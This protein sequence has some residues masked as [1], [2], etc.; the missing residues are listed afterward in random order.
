MDSTRNRSRSSHSRPAFLT[1]TLQ[2]LSNLFE[3]LSRPPK[4]STGGTELSAV[5]IPG[6]GGHRI[7]RDSIDHAILLVKTSSRPESHPTPVRLENLAVD[8]EVHCRIWQD[9]NV[10]E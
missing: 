5:E 9:N 10:I 2:T 1:L 8:H 6:L 4:S 7:A 3:G